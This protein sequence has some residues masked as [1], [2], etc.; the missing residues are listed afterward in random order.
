MKTTLEFISDLKSRYGIESDYA[1][2]K[3]LGIAKNT[4]SLYRNSKSHFSDEVAIKAA[5]LL[6][7]DAGY[8]M[9]CMAYERARTPLAKARWKHTADILYGLAAG[10]AVIF[11]LPFITLPANPIQPSGAFDNS[12]FYTS[13][14]YIMRI[15][16]AAKAE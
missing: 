5:E 4:M 11:F 9:A 3:L 12:A 13:G 10:L 14:I 8:V 6:G 2:A 16:G 7:I 1:L 15:S